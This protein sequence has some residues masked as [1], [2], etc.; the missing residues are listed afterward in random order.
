[1][2]SWRVSNIKMTSLLDKLKYFMERGRNG[3]STQDTWN[4]QDYL[5][6]IIPKAIRTLKS[7]Q[8]CPGKLYDSTATNNECHKWDTILE[9]IATGFEAGL[10]ISQTGC[11]KTTKNEEGLYTWEYDTEHAKILTKKFERGMDLFKTHFFD[12][13][14]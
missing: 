11:H 7:G 14:D 10:K 5:C 2:D 9:E 6:T 13:W 12:L 4:F 3:F 1:M 8:G